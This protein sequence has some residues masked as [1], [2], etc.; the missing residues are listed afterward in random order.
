MYILDGKK[1]NEN[2]YAITELMKAVIVIT[3]K[4]KS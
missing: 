3:K 2:L 4:K 1:Y